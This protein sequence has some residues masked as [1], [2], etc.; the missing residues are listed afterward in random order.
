MAAFRATHATCLQ[1]TAEELYM[2]VNAG[3]REKDLAHLNKHLGLFKARRTAPMDSCAI[4]DALADSALQAKGGH[5][6]MHIHDERALIALQG[7]KAAAAVQVCSC[8]EQCV[9]CSLRLRHSRS[10]SWT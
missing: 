2:V 1:V 4:L 7:P 9:S 5:V 6:S 10:P 3:C 8:T